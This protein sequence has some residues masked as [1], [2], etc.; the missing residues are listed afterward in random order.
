MPVLFTNPGRQVFSH[1]GPYNNDITVKPVLS[2]HSKKDHK[3]VFMTNYRIMQVKSTAEWQYFGPSLSYHLSLRPLF[4][5]Y[6]RGRLKQVLLYLTTMCVTSNTTIVLGTC[7][8]WDVICICLDKQKFSALIC[9]YFLT[10]N[11]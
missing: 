5:L 9:K 11:F 1:R 7:D 2:G 8:V 3:L 10:H 6:L 4:C